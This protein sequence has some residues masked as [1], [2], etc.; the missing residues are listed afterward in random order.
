MGAESDCNSR[1]RGR[2]W[3]TLAMG[4]VALS[5][6]LLRVLPAVA[7]PA[8]A[9]CV[10]PVRLALSAGTGPSGAP[11][12]V[13]AS[14]TNEERCHAWLLGVRFSPFGASPG[15]WGSAWRIP[16]GAQLPKK[17]TIASFDEQG[18]SGGVFTGVT[19]GEVA[20]VEVTM[21]SGRRIEVR[22]RAATTALREKASWLRQMRYFMRFYPSGEHV[23]AVKLLG[24]RGELIYRTSARDEGEF[25][26]PI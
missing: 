20:A 17:F 2:P 25:N 12:S 13:S 4:I 15:T 9:E 19:G 8:T 1:H 5:L 10:K 16:A 22:P 7:S 11:W 24:H 6:A 26:G 18:T 14:I 21:S 23:V 3:F